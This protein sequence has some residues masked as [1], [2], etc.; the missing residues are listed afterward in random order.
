MLSKGIKGIVA[1]NHLLLLGALQAIKESEKKL[2]DVIIVGFDDS[3]WNE[4]YTP[5]LTVISQ[6]VKEMGQVAAKMIYKLIKGKDVTSIK[7]STKLIIRESC[8]FNK[9]KN[10]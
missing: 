5:K 9:L 7:L 1:T 10:P 6:P 4:I 2:K 3:Y 8:S